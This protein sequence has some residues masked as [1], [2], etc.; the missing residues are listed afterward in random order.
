MRYLVILSVAIVFAIS[1]Q[2]AC[3]APNVLLI[4]ADDM[5]VEA[6]SVYGLGK[7]APKT[8]ASRFGMRTPGSRAATSTD[9]SRSCSAA[10]GIRL[11]TASCR[12]AVTRQFESG[13]PKAVR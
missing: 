9:T 12:L 5:G 10:V 11:A 13:T 1:C 4:R 8:A 3:L 6:L 2:R 7:T